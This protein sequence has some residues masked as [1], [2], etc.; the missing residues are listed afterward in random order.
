MGIFGVAVP[1]NYSWP[2]KVPSDY[3][4]ASKANAMEILP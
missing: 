1:K 3:D 4:K 2:E